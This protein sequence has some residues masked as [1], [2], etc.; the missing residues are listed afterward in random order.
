M[1]FKLKDKVYSHRIGNPFSGEITAIYS[2]GFAVQVMADRVPYI[3]RTPSGIAISDAHPWFK[4]D[5]NWTE[6]PV[7]IINLDTPDRP[8]SFMEF[9]QINNIKP[10]ED[11]SKIYEK[12]IPIV[13]QVSHPECD[14]YLVEEPVKT[15]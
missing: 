6:N 15:E 13:P 1:K 10:S 4:F 5:E 8:I 2:G 7:Y 11:S 3:V 14:L 9:C 12:S